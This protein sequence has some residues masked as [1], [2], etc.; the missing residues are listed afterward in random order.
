MLAV[1][2]W[3]LGACVPAG[4]DDDDSSGPLPADSV[5]YYFGTSTT[6]GVTGNWTETNTY[7]VRR[8]LFPAD[9]RITEELYDTG[10]G[11]DILVEMEVDAAAGTFTLA[12]ANGSYTGTGTLTGEA[13]AWMEWESIST[14][15]DGSTVQS[16]DT[17]MDDPALGTRLVVSKMGRDAAG[18][19]DWTAGEVFTEISESEW[20]ERFAEVPGR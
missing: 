12:F 16:N 1:L 13:W 4:G 9:S 15:A 3:A 8:S 6:S 20:L 7:L 17:L 2:G 18:I 5:E 14:A 19:L 11:T 10:D